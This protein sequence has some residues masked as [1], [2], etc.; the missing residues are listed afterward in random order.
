M[1]PLPLPLPL[2]LI[3]ESCDTIQFLIIKS[4]DVTKSTTPPHR[5]PY[6][7]RTYT[8]TL[9]RCTTTVPPPPHSLAR[10]PLL[11]I[12]KGLRSPREPRGAR[13][14]HPTLRIPGNS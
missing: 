14:P 13:Y 3:S 10:P 5:T 4:I 1:N 8:P 6:L 11:R 2:H 9:H 7:R 12:P